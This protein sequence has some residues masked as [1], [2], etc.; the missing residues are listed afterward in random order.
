MKQFSALALLT[1]LLISGTSNAQNSCFS[2]LSDYSFT[3]L[4]NVRCIEKGDFNNDTHQDLVIGINTTGTN[5]IGLLLGDGDGSFGAVTT[6]TAGGNPRFIKAYDFN[7]DGNLDFAVAN[8]F[9]HNVSIFIGNGAGGFAAAVN[10]GTG[11]SS[12]PN[13]IAIADIDEDGVMDLM[14]SVQAGTPGFAFLS[15]NATGTFDPF[16]NFPMGSGARTITTGDFNEDGHMDVATG[17][18]GSANVS[19]RLGTGTVALFGSVTNFAVGSSPFNIGCTDINADL[20]K[21]L[22]VSNSVSNTIS[23]LIGNGLGSFAV[24][25][26]YTTGSGPNQLMIED[27]NEDSELDV[28][29]VNNGENTV[30]LFTGTGVNAAG[31]RLNTQVKF[32]VIGTP[33]AMVSG[34]YNEDG[35]MDLAVPT[36]VGARIII[37]LG[38]GAG[39]FNTGSNISTQTGPL[40]IAM[41]DFNSDSKSDLVVANDMSGTIS[42]L[43]GNG[44]GTYAVG[45]TYM[46]GLNPSGMK[47]ADVNNDGFMD[48]IVTNA[49]SGTVSILL[50]DGLGGFAAAVDYPVGTTPVGVVC[51]DFNNDT[52]LDLAVVNSGSNNFSV[53]LGLGGGVF[54]VATNFIVGTSPR[55]IIADYFNADANLDIAVVN[56]TTTNF[57]VIFGDG[58]GSFSGALTASTG[59]VTTSPLSLAS[60]DMDGDGDKDIVIVN[61]G[62]SVVRV[63]KNSG[64][65]TFTAFG[66]YATDASPQSIVIA[67]F[68][69]DG[70]SDV[71]TAN[72][73]AA[74][75]T[76]T[77][78]VLMGNGTGALGTKTDF[79]ASNYTSRIIAGYI[80]GG[81]LIDLAVTNYDANNVSILLNTTAV[82]T[83][84]GAT[85]FCAGGSV[86]LSSTPGTTYLWSPGSATT[87]SITATTSGNYH[88]TTS[89]LSGLCSSQ[90]NDIVVTVN[91]APSIL[92]I[93]GSTTVCSSASTALTANASTGTADLDWYDM[94]S[95]GTML[96]STA[97]Y[98]TPVLG[99]TTTYY[100]EAVEPGTGCI[101]SPR[102]P[103]TVTVGDFASPVITGIPSNITLNAGAA[104][105]AVATWTAPNATDECGLLSFTSS[106]T[107]GSTF[108]FGTTTVTY[109]ATDNASHVTTASFTVTVN[110]VTNPVIS[111]MPS[112]ITTNVTAGSCAK[113]VTWTTPTASDNCGIASL[114][115]SVVSGSSFPVGTTT[116]TYTATDIHGLITTASFTV[117]VTDNILP[118]ISGMPSNQTLSASAGTCGAV[119]TWTTPTASDNCGIASL[120][121]TS[122]SGSTFPV[123]VTTVTY[124]ATDVNGNIST[125]NFTITVND[126]QLP[127]ISGTPSNITTNATTGLCAATVTW[128][129]P[130]ASD[131]C[132]IASLTPSSASGSSFP[133]GTTTVTYT[134][135][136]VNG[137]IQTSSFTVTVVD[138]QN[139]TFPTF[140]SNITTPAT[141]GSC[142]A[143][144]TWTTPTTADNCSVLSVTSTHT[145]GSTF[146]VGTPT[147]VTYTVTDINGNVTNQSFTVTVLDTEAPA[148]VGCP[149]TQT[150]C[151][152]DTVTYVDPTATDNCSGVTITQLAGLP[153]GS[154]F[155]IG[156]T[157]CTFRATDASGNITNCN[158]NIIVNANP[159]ATLT[160]PS[161]QICDDDLPI[162]ITGGSPAGGVYTGTGV[163][164]STFDPIAA[165]NGTHTITYTFTN[166][167][168]CSDEA[169]DTYV[170]DDC[171]GFT[172]FAASD[173]VRVYPNPTQGIFTVELNGTS[174]T[175]KT[176]AITNQLGEKIYTGNLSGT[177]NSIDLSTLA[178]GVY[179][180]RIEGVDFHS[181]T[182]L[183]IQK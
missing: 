150:V 158:F 82:I 148:I 25:D 70:F 108:A 12:G 173:L 56:N 99:S 105:T 76:G 79:I 165:D 57:T 72:R 68:N 154:V 125:A 20:H 80:D 35:H 137:N 15:G 130:T 81:T 91:P 179:L 180:V 168:G 111:G 21:D 74:G 53:L 133:V 24:T 18:S 86:M 151:E 8:N 127:T 134:A 64:T 171:T 167:S 135:T 103:V 131:N 17:N 112:N 92:S 7:S 152:N 93:T 96:S 174:V 61:N 46:V 101:M 22:V 161:V 181:T 13:G 163:T 172:D 45:V 122:T 147:T 6:F 126:T 97:S 42:Y 117:T 26:N 38:D 169:T 160:L 109:T 62:T 69:N 183:V 182:R 27:F 145:S 23:V 164:G 149:S 118:T 177:M 136:D 176:I 10:Y 144:I 75:A 5:N 140:P 128:T 116:V 29:V 106:H 1:G 138:A 47:S 115:P 159:S 28:A 52:N 88:V 37:M 129:T 31:S 85:S 11:T 55:E 34:D 123:G 90:S 51:K 44:D 95:A 142:D 32:P 73:V 146:S 119:A 14:V 63:L 143:V 54:G 113:V 41:A 60:S 157:L 43:E 9:T 58:T 121:G 40:G 166:G 2:S 48:V 98:T 120:T 100:I 178:N 156:T 94:P 162:T 30:S 78:S 87:S 36:Q 141:A 67:D 132:S 19:V 155:P 83:A 59:G 102:Y 110:D 170:V 124:T 84:T 65:G 66:N 153:S 89:N 50:G 104:C 49:G 39:D 114:T 33:Q 77:V 71:A 107:S 139:P 3:G 4:S 16:V 175:S